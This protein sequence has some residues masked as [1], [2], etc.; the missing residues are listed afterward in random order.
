MAMWGKPNS[1]DKKRRES[2]LSRDLHPPNS[3]LSSAFLAIFG[4]EIETGDK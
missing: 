4:S 1:A 2:V 3:N